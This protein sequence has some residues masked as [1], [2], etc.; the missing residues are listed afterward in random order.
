MAFRL[1]AQSALP[2]LVSLAPISWSAVAS[3]QVQQPN[4]DPIPQ[5]VRVDEINLVTGRGFPEDAVTLEGLFK[6]RDEMI[7]PVADAST[8]PGVFSPLCGFTGE[9]VLRGGGCK[10]AFGWYNATASGERPADNEIYQ[11]IPADPMMASGCEDGDFCPLATRETTQMGQHDW[12]P[13]PFDSGDIRNDPRYRGGL[14]GFALIG[15]RS[16]DCSQTKFSQAELN[17]T[18]TNCTPNAPWVTALIYQSTAT[19]DAFYIGFE[20]LPMSATDWKSGGGQYRNDGDFNDFVYFI[21]GVTCQGG[22]QP[23][24][25]G[26]EGICAVGKT[27][28]AA[29]GEETE[30]AQVV[31]ASAEKC[32]NIDNDC[33]GL[34]DNG[35]GLCAEGLIC[36]SGACVDPCGGGEFN[37]AIGLVCDDGLCV[38]PACVDKDCPAGTVCVGG[39]CVGGCEGVVC[40][41]GQECQLGRCVDLCAGVTCDEN[42]VCERGVCLS[43]CACRSSCGTGRACNMGSGQCVDAGC[44]SK[45][46][47]AG[48]ICKA[49]ECIDACQNVVCPGNA[50]CANGVCGEPIAITTAAASTG[51]SASSGDIVL[52]EASTGVAAG[53]GPSAGSGTFP[54][55]GAGAAGSGGSGADGGGQPNSGCACRTTP[56]PGGVPG[57]ASLLALGLLLLTRRGRRAQPRA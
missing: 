40:P 16:S 12:E 44:E 39:Q 3:A 6:Y 4:G 47:A 52:A 35:D 19:P 20:D 57:G 45:S 11:L 25:T 42:S 17:V 13:T 22:G 24:D 56:A 53:P 38:E 49:G 28:C 23:C 5:P 51:A 36:R 14:V 27:T 2:L 32:D 34:V 30:C 15:N 10:V 26:L 46:C 29:S 54:S 37:C 31:G 21:T 8:A 33:D 50:V 9:L 18:C 1:A 55:T 43:N 48:Q 41:E 7:D